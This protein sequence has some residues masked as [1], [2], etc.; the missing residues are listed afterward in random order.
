MWP[1]SRWNILTMCG[2]FVNEQKGQNFVFLTTAMIMRDEYTTHRYTR[3]WWQRLSYCTT[4]FNP[5]S[6]CFQLT[7]YDSLFSWVFAKNYSNLLTSNFHYYKTIHF[8]GSLDNT[9]NSYC[10][11]FSWFIHIFLCYWLSIVFYCLNTE[12]KEYYSN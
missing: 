12:C 11:L 3:M 8:F 1:A 10:H 4:C 2:E 7:F 5:S 6:I 9:M